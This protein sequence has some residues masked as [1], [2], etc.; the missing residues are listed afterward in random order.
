M[1]LH[2]EK[3]LYLEIHYRLKNEEKLPSKIIKTGLS[4]PLREPVPHSIL[5]DIMRVEKPKRFHILSWGRFQLTCTILYYSG[6]RI[7]EIARITPEMM[8]QKR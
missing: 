8:Y 5:L 7:N 3:F 1:V 4:L 2:R 6:L